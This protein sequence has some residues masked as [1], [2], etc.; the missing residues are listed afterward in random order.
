MEICD[1]NFS[2]NIEYT[3]TTVKLIFSSRLSNLKFEELKKIYIVIG[4]KQHTS[5]K[6]ENVKMEN[7]QLGVPY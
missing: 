6:W 3:Y 1:S 2:Y 5:S 7:S 4:V